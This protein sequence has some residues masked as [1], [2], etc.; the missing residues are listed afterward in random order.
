MEEITQWSYIRY[1]S[2][3][4]FYVLFNIFNKYFLS[5]CFMSYIVLSTRS[6]NSG[7]K[8]VISTFLHLIFILSYIFQLIKSIICTLFISTYIKIRKTQRNKHGPCRRMTHKFVKRSVFLRMKL[9]ILFNTIPKINSK[10]IKDLN[11]R[12]DTIKLLEENVGR[13]LSDINLSS[14]FFDRLLE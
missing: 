9:K 8:H 11:I 14:I 6:K 2:L 5:A 10:W 13:T 12:L 1:K 4:K 3:L 7:T